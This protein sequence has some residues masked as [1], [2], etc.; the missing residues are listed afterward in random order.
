ML[1][2]QAGGFADAFLEIT[3]CL[4]GNVS[5]ADLFG[6]AFV[7]HVLLN[8]GVASSYR[9]TTSPRMTQPRSEQV[10]A[11]MTLV[12][13]TPVISVAFQRHNIEE[14]LD[15]DRWTNA[16][17]LSVSA[18]IPPLRSS[19]QQTIRWSVPLTFPKYPIVKKRTESC[20]GY[21]V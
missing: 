17:L 7:L 8:E 12:A 20:A 19:R 10:D 3:R 4:R 15:I 11:T 18:P 16:L 5:S 6:G 13:C 1:Q 9:A 21:Q 14:L 2:R